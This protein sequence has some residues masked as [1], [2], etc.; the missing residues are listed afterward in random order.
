MKTI[1]INLKPQTVITKDNV[2]L[3][4]DTTV[5]YRTINPYK[6]VYKLG[7]NRNE[8]YQFISEMSHSAMRTVVGETTFQELL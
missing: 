1:V 6:L 3:R 5:Y 7:N 8:L 4:I 2:S